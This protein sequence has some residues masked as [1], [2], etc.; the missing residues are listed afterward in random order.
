[1]TLSPRTSSEYSTKPFPVL[2][3]G[4]QVKVEVVRPDETTVPPFP[5]ETDD[6]I[7][8]TAPIGMN[9]PLTRLFENTE[10]TLTGAVI[11]KLS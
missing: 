8:Q 6:R 3:V 10:V 1:L 2:P 9:P 7:S 4:V 11:V 5:A